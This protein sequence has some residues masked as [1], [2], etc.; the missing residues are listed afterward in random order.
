MINKYIR[1]NKLK[2]KED[3]KK[4]GMWIVTIIFADDRA[5]NRYR[6]GHEINLAKGRVESTKWARIEAIQDSVLRIADNRYLLVS[7]NVEQTNTACN[8]ELC[9]QHDDTQY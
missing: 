4:D 5:Y 8:T 3:R 7:G 1:T 6:D 9:W 2:Y